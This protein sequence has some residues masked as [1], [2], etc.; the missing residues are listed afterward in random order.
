[1]R[2]KRKFA[3]ASCYR[4]T[5]AGVILKDIYAIIDWH[6]VGDNTYDKVSQTSAFWSYMAPR[7]ANDSHVLFELFNEPLNTSGSTDAQDW[8]T[9]KTDMQTWIDIVRASAP[10]NLILVAG[11]FYSQLI[12]PAAD[13][14][15]RELTSLW[16]FTPI[17]DIG[18]VPASHG[19]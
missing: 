10:N 2:S 1:M 11:P 17:P 5:A 12:G 8:A 7:F 6:Y 13:D 19:I 18:I 9:C 4:K 16:W 14:P 15:L 3:P